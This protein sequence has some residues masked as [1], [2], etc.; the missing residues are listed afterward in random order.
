M[1]LFYHDKK[2]CNLAS[3]VSLYTFKPC[4]G[5]PCK[6]RRFLLKFFA[7]FPKLFLAFLQKRVIFSSK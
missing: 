5:I 2:K 3:K 4:H 1:Q 6:Q 7:T